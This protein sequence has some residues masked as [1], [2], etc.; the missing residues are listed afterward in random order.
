MFHINSFYLKKVDSA[1]R[2]LQCFTKSKLSAFIYR[3][4]LFP[5]T[6]QNG[7]SNPTQIEEYT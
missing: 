2:K 5:K 3:V 1:V 4:I 6:R 7:V